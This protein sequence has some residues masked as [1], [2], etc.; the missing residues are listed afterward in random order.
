MVVMELYVGLTEM[1]RWWYMQ[2][3]KKNI[4]TINAV[5]GGSKTRLLNILMQLRKVCNH[6]YLFDG[7]RRRN[8]QGIHVRIRH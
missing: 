6:P 7:H 1:Q 8:I 5:G 3:L 4:D 2:L